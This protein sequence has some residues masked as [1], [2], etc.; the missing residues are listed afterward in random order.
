[1]TVLTGD[2]T[3]TPAVEGPSGDG[4]GKR[5]GGHEQLWYTTLALGIA[6]VTFFAAWGLHGNT[7][8]TYRVGLHTLPPD[9][10][11]CRLGGHGGRH[12]TERSFCMRGAAHVRAAAPGL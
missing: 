5:P 3:G 4:G 2:Q 7:P 9:L 8:S 6:A 12:W 1:M 10:H 11:G